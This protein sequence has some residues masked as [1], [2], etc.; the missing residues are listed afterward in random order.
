MLVVHIPTSLEGLSLLHWSGDT[1]SPDVIIQI[2]ASGLWGCEAFH[3]GRW[4]QWEWTHEW[5]SV[6]I[7]AMELTPIILSCV[8]WG[9][10][11]QRQKVLF[12]CDNSSVVASIHKRSCKDLQVMH[13]LHTLTFFTA[14]YDTEIMAEHIPGVTNTTAD[15]LSRNIMLMFFCLNPQAHPLP[16]PLPPPLLAMLTPP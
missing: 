1:Q 15:H 16:T 3:Q 4:L 7:M 13:L 9:R 6:G 10:A 2:D 12:Q 8:V 5:T 14:Y 11:L